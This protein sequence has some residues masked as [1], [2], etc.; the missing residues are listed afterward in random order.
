MW[1]NRWQSNT[2]PGL[3]VKFEGTQGKKLPRLIVSPPS[4]GNYY[5]VVALELPDRG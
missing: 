3:D 1:Q 5:G 4:L 2:D